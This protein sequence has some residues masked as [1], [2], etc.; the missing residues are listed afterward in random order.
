MNSKGKWVGG[1]T[2]I[3]LCP[4]VL[5]PLH[6]SGNYYIWLSNSST[7]LCRWQLEKWPTNI[8]NTKVTIRCVHLVSAKLALMLPSRELKW[9]TVDFDRRSNLS[10]YHHSIPANH[11][12]TQDTTLVW[13]SHKNVSF[14]IASE[15]SYV[16]I[17]SRQ[18]LIKNAKN[19][20]FAKIWKI[21]MRLFLWFSN[22]VLN[23]IKISA[24]F[25]NF[26][27]LNILT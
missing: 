5:T 3:S 21:Q 1:G 14:N 17:L 18:K 26:C 19:G 9:S 10:Y 15:A 20:Q 8:G 25:I 6:S 23:R 12:P 13:K 7:P 4:A 27:P 24:F 2:F 16:Y 22:T 11:S